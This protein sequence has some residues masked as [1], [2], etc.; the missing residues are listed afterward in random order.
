VLLITGA[1]DISTFHIPYTKLVDR[2]TRLAQYLDSLEYAIANYHNITHIVF[3]DNTNYQYDYSKLQEKAQQNGKIL[4]IL[5]FFGDYDAIQKRG[6]GY[7]EGEIIEYALTVSEALQKAECFYKLTGRIIVRN[8]D[9]IVKTTHSDTAFLFFHK[10]HWVQTV[11]YKV[12]TKLYKTIL[13]NAYKKAQDALNGKVG[14]NLEMAFLDALVDYPINSLG[15]Y[16][17]LF[18]ISGGT[19]LP[20]TKPEKEFRDASLLNRLGIFSNR[21]VNIYQKILF[22]LCKKLKIV[23]NIV[24]YDTENYTLLLAVR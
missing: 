11:F 22:Y 13:I 24:Y 17:L 16:P 10:Q 12:N 21:K 14:Y 9:K 20:Y 1:I 8:M 6:K 2:N 7:G 23:S 18:G 15:T 5:T 4:E 3:C 19:G